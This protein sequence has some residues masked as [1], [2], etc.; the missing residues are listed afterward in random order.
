MDGCSDAIH[1]SI[2]STGLSVRKPKRRG[3]ELPSRPHTGED[4]GIFQKRESRTLVCGSPRTTPSVPT[5]ATTTMDRVQCRY[6]VSRMKRMKPALTPSSNVFVRRLRSLTLTC[7]LSLSLCFSLALIPWRPL[8]EEA[9]QV[10][11]LKL[12]KVVVLILQCFSPS[13]SPS[14]LRLLLFGFASCGPTR[15]GAVVVFQWN[16]HFTSLEC[17]SDLFY[18]TKS[19]A[20]GGK[21]RSF[22]RSSR[23]LISLSILD[24][25]RLE[26]PG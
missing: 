21:W 3:R 1:V 23:R 6:P 10:E 19:H 7:S 12:S 17:Q 11:I 9:I 22:A 26:E 16:S 14:A 5:A 13:S 20:E 4:K 24:P 8:T 18:E 15:R 2:T 25:G